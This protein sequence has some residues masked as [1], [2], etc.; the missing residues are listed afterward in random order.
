M[1]RREGENR[2]TGDP[3]HKQD[4]SMVFQTSV[5]PYKSI[6]ECIESREEDKPP[7]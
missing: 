2:G 7:S 4:K 1:S 6:R 5:A 3:F